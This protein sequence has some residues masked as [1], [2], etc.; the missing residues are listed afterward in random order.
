MPSSFL[1]A[2]TNFYLGGRYDPQAKRLTDEAVYYDSRD[3]VTHAVVVGMTG[4]GKTGLCISM[5][6]EAVIDRLPA[7]IID[8][9][10][11]ITNL[12]LN[13]PE[14]RAADF[15][16]WINVDDA[17]RA[18]QTVPEFAES[19]AAKWRKGLADWGIIPQRLELLKRMAEFTIYTPGSDSGVPVSVL[20]SFEAPDE[21]WTGNEEPLRDEINAVVGAIFTLIG[22]D[23]G[24]LA[25]EHALLATIFETAWRQGRDLKIDD[26]IAQIKQPPFDRLG[27]IPLD[28]YISE[29]ARYKLAMEVNTIAASPTFRAWTAG[30]PIDIHEMLYQPNRRPRV[31]IFY[32]AHLSDRER[33]FFMTLLLEKI[34]SWMRKQSGTTSLRALLYIDELFGYFPP[35]PYNPPTKEPL[36]TLLKQARAYGLGLILASQNPGDLDYKGLTNAGTWFIGRLSSDNDKDRVMAGL[37]AMATANNNTDLNVISRWVSDLPSRVFLMRNLHDPE[38]VLVHSRWAMSYLRGPLTRPQIRELMAEQR[39][40]VLAA[41]AA[42]GGV[43]RPPNLPA[44]AVT[45]AAPPPTLP[46][47]G[48]APGTVASNMPPPINAAPA[49]PRVPDHLVPAGF[50]AS[51]P[52]VTARI[53][54]HFLPVFISAPMAMQSWAQRAGVPAQ[55]QVQPILTY[56]PSIY[57]HCEVRFQDQ[58]AQIFTVESYAFQVAELDPAAMV[59]WERWQVPLIDPTLLAAEPAMPAIFSEVPP[60]MSDSTRHTSLRRE[61]VDFLYATVRLA[62]PFVPELK[63][64]GQ[65]G[66]SPDAFYDRARQL[67]REQRDAEVEKLTLRYGSQIDKL[68]QRIDRHDNEL[69]YRKD[70]LRV[71]GREEFLM[72]GHA[73]MNLFQG[74]R[75]AY[76]LAQMSR[77][78]RYSDYTREKVQ[79][80]KSARETLD[81]SIKDKQTEFETLATQINDKWERIIASQQQHIVTP[82][83]KDI[84]LRIFGVGWVPYWY[85][86]INGQA[87]LISALA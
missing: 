75:M 52:P 6:E 72:K 87:V 73:L 44:A 16:P 26:L 9:K 24:P 48:G 8:P 11:D 49:Q 23:I 28:E 12:L 38:P 31:S 86:V 10:G 78:G 13:F 62:V 79:E 47:L 14:L 59:Q 22:K 4:S 17:L 27:V 40:R 20:S 63:L 65:L 69:R 80:Q 7:I 50:S 55:L 3:L 57:A 58:K 77:A 35:H 70:E 25:K 66:E 60:A 18:G 19:E 5:L 43:E 76:S 67:A 53:S 36:M 68:A 56:Y 33:M 32:I 42:N 21:G 2:P 82:Y 41:P 30:V 83:K 37:E 61:V 15:E 54:Q 51:P 29:R 39:A 1:E 64:Y 74:R 34:I 84:Q 45:Q 85:A 71:R 81:L 46:G